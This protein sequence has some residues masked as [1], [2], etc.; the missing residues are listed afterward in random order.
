MPSGHYQLPLVGAVDQQCHCIGHN[1]RQSGHQVALGIGVETGHK[2][3]ALVSK[4]LAAVIT[5][6][7]I[8]RQP[9]ADVLQQHSFEQFT[10]ARREQRGR[11]GLGFFFVSHKSNLV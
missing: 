4:M 9:C 10:V 2:L 11:N 3:T 5:N 7:H 6:G 1:L 8:A